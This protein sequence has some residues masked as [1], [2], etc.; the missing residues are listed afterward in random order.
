MAGVEDK[1]LKAMKDA[2]KPVRP[3]DLATATGLSK[4]EISGAL[5]KLKKAGKI[6]SPKRCFWEPA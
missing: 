4:E 3:G 2:G 5:D 1:V 6:T